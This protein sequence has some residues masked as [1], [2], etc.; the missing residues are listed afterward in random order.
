MH[1]T[2]AAALRRLIDASDDLDGERRRRALQLLESADVE[3]SEV[4][5]LPPDAREGVYR[6]ALGIVKLDGQVTDDERAFIAR[7]RQAIDLDE[8]TLARIEAERR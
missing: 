6:A 8:T 4:K 1:P 3:L 5:K 2:E 7:L